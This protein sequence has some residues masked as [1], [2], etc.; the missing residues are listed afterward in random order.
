MVAVACVAL[1]SLPAATVA[2]AD[3]PFAPADS[4]WQPLRQRALA[5]PTVRLTPAELALVPPEPGIQG[6]LG[7]GSALQQSSGGGS[8][9]ICT[10]AFILRDPATAR[11]YL[12]TAGH[13][14]VKDETDTN[15]YTGA[16][17]PDKMHSTISICVANCVENIL[18]LGTYVDLRADGAYHPVAFAQSGGVG[19]DFGIIELPP[20]VH[21]H[22]RP[23]MPMWG[24]PTGYDAAATSTYVV[25]YGHGSYCCA[26]V[27]AVATRTPADQGRV[28][29]FDGTNSDGSFDATGFSSG[30]DSGS[31]VSLAAAGGADALVGT[32]ALGVLTHGFYIVHPA[33]SIPAFAGTT[34]EKGFA[35][36]SETLGLALELVPEGDPLSTTP[37]ASPPEL[38]IV[39]PAAGE[40]LA[41]GDVVTIHGTIGNGAIPDGAEVQVA[42]DDA[43]YPDDRRIPVEGDASWNAT[44]FLSGELPGEHTIHARLVSGLHTLSEANTTVTIEG[45]G[46][47]PSSGS[48]SS[49]TQG[50]PTSSK[51]TAATSASSG[52]AAVSQAKAAAGTTSASSSSSTQGAPGL[53]ILLV[54]AALV[55]AAFARRR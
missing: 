17:N 5:E 54:A 55:G 43:S 33:A 48:A 19:T 36:V 28:G 42:I 35:M 34:L 45:K 10:A 13:C 4:A 26:G 20:A 18:G 41:S 27:G 31:G 44:W 25:H 9:Y 2:V 49:S 16:A 39:S 11:Y 50:G 51:P 15:P 8:F 7:P 12:A 23:A 52:S 47:K 37:T 40:R 1:S 3:A 21:T 6:G 24:G 46:A 29:L 30:G 32:T 53:E 38:L 14:L 22:I